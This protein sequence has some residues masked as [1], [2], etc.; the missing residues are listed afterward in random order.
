MP[1]NER[2]NWGP[3][4]SFL[5]SLPS[6]GVLTVTGY[7]RIFNC[8]GGFID[9]AASC[10]TDGIGASLYGLLVLLSMI[11]VL[12]GIILV[13]L[14]LFIAIRALYKLPREMQR[15]MTWKLA[16]IFSIATVLI[17]GRVL[18]FVAYFS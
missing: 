5:L 14:T 4:V 15:D 2:V 1:T 8:M 6:L 10:A 11:G 13:P 16:W 3:A 9:T 12:F 17:Q 7:G 18:L